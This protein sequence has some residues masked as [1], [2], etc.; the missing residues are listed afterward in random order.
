MTLI[1]M[2]VGERRLEV[3]IGGRP[4][5]LICLDLEMTVPGVYS[6]R[7]MC[8][9]IYIGHASWFTYTRMWNTTGTYG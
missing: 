5:L 4:L 9:Q 6:I 8:V 3:L 7:C 1:L 2:S